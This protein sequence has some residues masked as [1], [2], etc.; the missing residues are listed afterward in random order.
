MAVGFL[1]AAKSVE[2]DGAKP[3]VGQDARPAHALVWSLDLS[4]TA[5]T[6]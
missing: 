6:Q 4:R 3:D 5:R 1:R 2:V